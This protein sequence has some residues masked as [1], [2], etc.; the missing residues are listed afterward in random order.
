M[1]YH[2]VVLNRHFPYREIRFYTNAYVRIV[3]YN[4]SMYSDAECI[5]VFGIWYFTGQGEKFAMVS[6]GFKPATFGLLMQR[7]YQLS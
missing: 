2:D 6:V 3:S 7:S 4:G 5:L 1:F